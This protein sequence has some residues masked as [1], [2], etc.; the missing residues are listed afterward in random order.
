MLRWLLRLVLLGVT[1][2]GALL[3]IVYPIAV[4]TVDGHEIGSWR[5]FDGEGE[6]ETVEPSIAP[7]EAPVHIYVY[8]TVDGRFQPERERA[9]LA[10]TVTADGRTII[11]R[12]VPFVDY[13]P[14]MDSP[15][16]AEAVYADHAGTIDPADAD[17]YLV[18]VTP[19]DV[20]GIDIVAVDVLLTAR[21][22]E[23]DPLV[24]PIGYV[25]LAVGLVGLILSFRRR[26]APP[27]KAPPP[28]PRWG[29]G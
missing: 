18:T 20:D 12:P 19:Q 10:V 3:G 2:L 23:R 16:A 25:F 6:Y 29:R 1:L 22:I 28:P 21:A 5:V 14:T 26:R 9:I 8:L 4:E 27:G 11:A 15:Q 17:R 13:P 24:A 7:S